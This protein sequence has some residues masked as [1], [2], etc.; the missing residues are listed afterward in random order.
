MRLR[1]WT[2]LLLLCS[3]APSDAPTQRTLQ[4]TCRWITF[5]WW[6]YLAQL[7]VVVLCVWSCLLRNAYCEQEEEEEEE[8]GLTQYKGR[9]VQKRKEKSTQAIGRVH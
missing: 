9:P 2:L 1:A 8:V 5:C 3:D 7:V 6:G 4:C